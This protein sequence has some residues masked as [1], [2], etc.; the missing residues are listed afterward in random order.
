[1]ALVGLT[2][3]PQPYAGS[4]WANRQRNPLPCPVHNS[5]QL[6]QQKSESFQNGRSTP[7]RGGRQRWDIGKRG[8]FWSGR[9]APTHVQ[10]RLRGRKVLKAALPSTPKNL[11]ACRA[12]LPNQSPGWDT[13]LGCP[14]A[15]PDRALLPAACDGVMGT[16]VASLLKASSRP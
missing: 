5:H 9:A 2:V 7:S 14:G 3:W 6:R 15:D 1:M 10:C 12:N 16:L 13:R 11:E 8:G 4:K